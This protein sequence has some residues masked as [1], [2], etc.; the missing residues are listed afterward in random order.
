MTK[1]MNNEKLSTSNE[2]VSTDNQIKNTGKSFVYR[3]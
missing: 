2:I 1:K 3:H